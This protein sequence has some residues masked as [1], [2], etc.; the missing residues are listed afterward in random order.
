MPST[1]TSP[2][3][4]PAKSIA[5]RA[6]ERAFDTGFRTAIVLSLAS[7]FGGLVALQLSRA[8]GPTTTIASVLF[9]LG[10]G[11]ICLIGVDYASLGVVGLVRA[12]KR[13]DEENASAPRSQ[14]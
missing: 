14:P 12:R 11:L 9:G 10:C 13:R 4:T 3:A 2:S 6:A 7:L 8:G 5:A 1:R